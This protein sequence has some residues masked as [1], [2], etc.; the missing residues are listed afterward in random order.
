MRQLVLILT[1]ALF[2]TLAIKA[3]TRMI[4][5]K[6][7]L[8][9]AKTIRNIIIYRYSDLIM[10]YGYLNEIDT[11]E[12]DCKIR[13]ISESSRLDLISKVAMK[14]TDLA[15]KWPEIGDT[16]LIVIST[17]DR[18]TL[19]AT[20]NRNRYRFWDPNSTPW[21]NSAFSIIKQR[22]FIPLSD[23]KDHGTDESNRW[24]CRDGCLAL[25]FDIKEK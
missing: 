13:A 25:T 17:D 5:I 9:E 3:N 23:C 8:D 18:A 14:Q 7:T 15:G 16:V 20:K 4:D 12:I 2:T 19:F 24:I 1:L 11:L 21:S 10:Y 6:E 22:P